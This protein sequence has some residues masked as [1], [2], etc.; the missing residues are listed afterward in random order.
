MPTPP[1]RPLPRDPYRNLVLLALLTLSGRPPAHELLPS[2]HRLVSRALPWGRR[3]PRAR[4]YPRVRLRVLRRAL[5]GRRPRRGAAGLR[6]SPVEGI[7]PFERALEPLDGLDPAARAGYALLRVEALAPEE[8]A[9]LLRRAGA[10]DPEGALDRA[11]AVADGFRPP[12]PT[13]VRVSGRGAPPARGAL[14]AAGAGLLVLAL[15]ALAL[16]TQ[17]RPG[18]PGPAAAPVEAAVLTDGDAWRESFR[19]DLTAWPARGD[20][21]G[22]EG[23][24]DAALAA[25]TDHDG[26]APR[27]P[28][29][30]FAGRVDGRDVVLLHDAP[31]TARYTR[32]GD[33][34]DVEVFAEPA[35]G[36]AN[37]PAV[38]LSETAEG[39]RYLLPPWVTE[40]ASA[41]LGSA[42]EGW[43][44]VP[45]D[46]HGVTG[47]LP[48]DGHC[49]TGPVLRLRAPEVAHGQP[50]TV[51]DLGGPATAHLGYMPP[52]PAEIRRL[53]PHEVLDAEH[54]F[55]LWGEV[56][57]AGGP[58]RGPV[59]TATAWEFAV[60]DLPGGGSGRWVCLRYGTHDGG[61]LA[62][63]VLVATTDEGTA[64]VVAG[65][66]AGGWACSNLDRQVV[67]GTWWEAPDGRW[68]YLAA[69]SREAASV[70]VSG[71]AEGD[72][73]GPVLAV[74]GPRL[75]DGPP[76]A[77]VEVSAVDVRGGAM[78]PITG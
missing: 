10:A 13:V 34:E 39:V 65:E 23:L 35:N 32:D 31:R 21:V 5:R 30:V 76:A 9:A 70:R 16:T 15:A 69:A 6:V 51:V 25:W 2:A 12:D 66:S 54:G 56:A 42:E 61:G 74:A 49:G 77:P 18:P 22:D 62:R 11:A 17:A 27:D 72:G 20:A 43:A 52:P 19:L 71:G 33:A 55:D 48:A 38:R 7:T 73:E 58:P 44:E 26:R 1:V 24:A 40:A 41:S 53:G 47:P 8:A 59:V 36:V 46:E 68:H 29:L 50:Y 28:R 4:E 78:T 37:W 45:R 14:A 75:G 64:A 67:A 60:Q 63:A 57:C 3:N